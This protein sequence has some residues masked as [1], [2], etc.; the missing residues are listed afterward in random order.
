MWM[1]CVRWERLSERVNNEPTYTRDFFGKKFHLTTKPLVQLK[2]IR[3]IDYRFD[4]TCFPSIKRFFFSPITW[5]TSIP[6]EI[7]SWEPRWSVTLGTK[8]LCLT[9]SWQSLGVNVDSSWTYGTSCAANSRLLGRARGKVLQW[10]SSI[11]AT[12]SVVDRPCVMHY[13]T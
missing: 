11:Q 8:T 3:L 9:I 6:K 12:H 2:Y 10:N 1:K 7:L 5:N 13:F 4:I